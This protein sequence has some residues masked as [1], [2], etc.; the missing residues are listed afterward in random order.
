M[1][2]P[3]DAAPFSRLLARTLPHLRKLDRWKRGSQDV[4]L[5]PTNTA[6]SR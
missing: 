2:P 3:P 1:I 4:S 6:L 5:A